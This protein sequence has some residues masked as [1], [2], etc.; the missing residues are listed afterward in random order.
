MKK[1]NK[2][3]KFLQVINLGLPI[4]G[5]CSV[6]E[7]IFRDILAVIETN[8]PPFFR[9][10]ITKN[11]FLLQSFIYKIIVQSL[12]KN[13]KVRAIRGIISTVGQLL[14]E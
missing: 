3:I 7:L 13:T 11:R 8:I 10:I 6:G 14:R 1:T 12:I 4:S 5:F 9:K 2:I